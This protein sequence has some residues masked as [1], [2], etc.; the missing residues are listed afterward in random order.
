MKALIV[1][2]GPHE[3][4]GALE[5]LARRL[6]PK[7]MVCDH[8]R[9]SSP[10]V[11]THRGKGAGFFK[12]AVAWLLEAKR[13]GYDALVLVIDEDGNRERS[14]E[15][16]D[17]QESQLTSFSRALGVA[18]RS[19]DAWILADETA[20]TSVL[21]HPISRHAAPET[22]K[23]PKEDCKSLRDQCGKEIAL[24]DM[25]REVM[26]VADLTILE[27]RCPKGFAPFA[28]RVRCL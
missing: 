9:V 25:Y 1:S 23:N 19:F 24:R 16:S 7:L 14:K 27:D 21:Q 22:I 2:E 26:Q 11:H 20:I 10:S 3:L 5:C 4:G 12:R 8:D 13:R 18:I 28:A 17:A 15:M 6:A